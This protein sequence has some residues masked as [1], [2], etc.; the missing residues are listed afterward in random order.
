MNILLLGHGKTGSLVGTVARERGHQVSVLTSAENPRGSGILAARDIDAAIDVTTPHA[1][2]ENI[3]ACA[4]SGINLVVATTGWYQEIPRIRELVEKSGIG[5]VYASNFSVGVN[6]FFDIASLAATAARHGYTAQIV[7]RHHIHKK[8]APSGTAVTIRQKLEVTTNRVDAGDS[9]ALATR[10]VAPGEST[11]PQ[12]AGVPAGHGGS[13]GLQPGE[14]TPAMTPG[15]SP[16]SVEIQSI[17]EG[18]V[19]GEHTIILES[20]ADTITLQHSA[21]SRRGFAEGA[22]TAAEWVKGKRGFY[23]FHDILSQ[24]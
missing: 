11:R 10:S 22:V 13:T 5:L 15:F 16:G 1:V 8:D 20:P 19:V 9:P 23:E 18:E 7:E 12:R 14:S 17:R 21:K 24:L 4:R 2:L 6:L 3:E